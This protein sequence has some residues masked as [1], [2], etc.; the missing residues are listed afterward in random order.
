MLLLASP[1]DKASYI[2][3]LEEFLRRSEVRLFVSLSV[4]IRRR[5]YGNIESMEDI[6]HSTSSYASACDAWLVLSMRRKSLATEADSI[7]G[8]AQS[9]T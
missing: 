4:T 2:L 8:A 1:C 7:S 3:R 9:I 5:S 6:F